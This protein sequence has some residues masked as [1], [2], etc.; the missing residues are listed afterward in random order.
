[1][2]STFNNMHDIRADFPCLHQTI[3]G[4]PL[5]F[6]DS[7]ASAQK[8]LACIDALADCYKYSYANI[9]RG[10]YY[11][12]DK[13][14]TA[15]EQSRNHV[16]QFIHAAQPEEIIFTKGATEAINLVAHG[17]AHTINE[18]DEIIISQME[19][20][21]NIVPWQQ[22]CKQTGA[23]LNVCPITSDDTLDL[24]QFAQL[25]TTRTKIVAITHMSNVLGTI[26]PVKELCAQAQAVG[27]ITLIDACQSVVHLDIDVRDINCDFLVFSAHKLYGPN[28]VGVLYGKL[29]ALN[30]LDVYQTGGEMVDLVTFEQT[31]F[32][33]APFKFEAGTPSIAEV[34]A[35][36]HTLHYLEQIDFK[37]A[38]THEAE[39]LAYAHKEIAHIPG[40]HVIGHAP[41]KAGVLSFIHD[42]AHPSDIGT[43]LDQCGV[44]IR[45]GHQCAQPLHQS[46]G[47]HASARMSLGI[48]N[49]Q[50]DIDAFLEGLLKVNKLFGES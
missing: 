43:L 32:R 30:R 8:P 37:N 39:L 49:N 28:A 21:A 34:I 1:M 31:S 5:V 18:G 17:L 35:F 14:T 44:A 38:R 6:L 27:A 23:I 4:K 40:Y 47:I 9:H 36:D 19:H 26:N 12:S 15:F 13:A 10:L 25:L 16:A 20:H 33:E 46:R 7:A 29:T 22:L 3:H 2:T 24:D 50:A 42:H 11:L 48:Y 41:Q 45:T